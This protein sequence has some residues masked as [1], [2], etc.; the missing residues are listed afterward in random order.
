[1]HLPQRPQV[2]DERVE[3]RVGHRREVWN[4]AQHRKRHR[5]SVLEAQAL[6][7]R[8]LHPRVVIL[9]DPELRIG[10]QVR[11]PHLADAPG[12]ERLVRTA[13]ERVI[14]L[15]FR[16]PAAERVALFAVGEIHDVLS[17]G[18][19]VL[20]IGHR[21]VPGRS[22]VYEAEPNCPPR[23]EG[24]VT[25]EPRPVRPRLRHR[26][27]VGHDRAHVGVGHVLVAEER[28]HREEQRPFVVDAVAD[29]ARDP[30]VGPLAQAGLRVRS[31]VRDVELEV[32]DVLER[33]A[34]GEVALRLLGIGEQ[35]AGAAGVARSAGS[36]RIDEVLAAGDFVGRGGKRLAAGVA[37][38]TSRTAGD[39]QADERGFHW[40]PPGAPYSAAGGNA[41]GE[42]FHCLIDGCSVFSRRVSMGGSKEAALRW[43]MQLL[44]IAD[45]GL[46][47]CQGEGRRF[48]PGVPRNR[49][50]TSG[51]V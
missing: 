8:V 46:P 18:D 51:N 30:I 31:Q 49:W 48:E 21:H 45:G 16:P 17:V 23:H 26:A 29:G 27:Q 47:R 1:M 24:D 10:R 2:R 3:I 19:S 41:S 13:H 5:L 4:V 20:S 37:N 50:L 11:G 22:V 42:R 28:H 25:I 43:S 40:N 36:D 15:A 9:R 38:E 44:I 32:A 7:E 12:G 14:V 35:A 39:Q 33:V 34:A 6:A